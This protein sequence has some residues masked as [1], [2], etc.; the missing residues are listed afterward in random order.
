MGYRKS[1]IDK[2]KTILLQPVELVDDYVVNEHGGVVK[3]EEFLEDIQTYIIIKLKEVGITITADMD[4]FKMF[5]LYDIFVFMGNTDIMLYMDV[6]DRDIEHKVE[7]LGYLVSL[8]TTFELSQIIHDIIYV[9]DKF[10]VN[11]NERV[12]AHKED[13]EKRGVMYEY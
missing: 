10:G 8:F 5:E 11:F 9:D 6:L 2:T 13:L 12:L 7:D 1:I 4:I 3:F